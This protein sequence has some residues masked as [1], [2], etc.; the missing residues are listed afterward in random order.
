MDDIE[1]RFEVMLS[2][3]NDEKGRRTQLL[4]PIK[5]VTTIVDD[6]RRI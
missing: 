4:M 5:T 2:A 3:R 1:E 6:D